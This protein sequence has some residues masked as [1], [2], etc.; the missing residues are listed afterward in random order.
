M[1]PSG[2]FTRPT[3]LADAGHI[4][5]GHREFGRSAARD[6]DLGVRSIPG[7]DGVACFLHL[8]QFVRSSDDVITAKMFGAQFRAVED[9]LDVA[10]LE[11]VEGCSLDSDAAFP[12]GTKAS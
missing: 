5:L 6:Q 10:L 3:V 9:G 12:L 11:C 2:G 1:L 7:H 4:S 8:Q